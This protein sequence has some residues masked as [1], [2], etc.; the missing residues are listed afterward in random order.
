M[1]VVIAVVGGQ[2]EGPAAT[3]GVAVD[4]RIVAVGLRTC[5]A[6]R[7]AAVLHI[8]KSVAPAGLHGLAGGGEVET[9]IVADARHRVAQ[10]RKQHVVGHSRRQGVESIGKGIGIHRVARAGALHK[11][12]RTPLHLGAR[13]VGT[14]TVPTHRSTMRS[15]AVD[16]AVL[17][18]SIRHHQVVNPSRIG[19]V[20]AATV[21]V[22]DGDVLAGAV[23]AA[24]RNDLLLPAVVGIGRRSDGHKGALVARVAHHAHLHIGGAVV[25]CISEEADRQPLHAVH[26]EH[27]QHHSGVVVAQIAL[28]VHPHGAAAAMLDATVHL[29]I[30]AHHR[31]TRPARRELAVV[32]SLE[33]LAQRQRRVGLEGSGTDTRQVAHLRHRRTS[34]VNHKVVGRIGIEAREFQPLLVAVEG[35]V[36]AVHRD[37][38]RSA[39]TQ[40]ETR[41][42]ILDGHTVASPALTDGIPKHV[43]TVRGDVG[44]GLARH[45][46]RSHLEVVKID[47]VVVAVL[48]VGPQG[49]VAPRIGVR[50][51]AHRAA[52]PA[53]GAV[54]RIDGYK[55]RLILR[56]LHHAHHNAARGIVVA[57]RPEA[58]RQPADGHRVYLRQ[59]RQRTVAASDTEVEAACAAVLGAG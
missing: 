21:I 51:Q 35:C 14:H 40:R 15:D 4:T 24:Q 8:L 5:P 13:K 43:D 18:S 31:R 20:V 45:Q 27:G 6:S 7:I 53:Q 19:A 34:A 46:A 54:H 36:G 30:A 41:R 23:V 26:I 16:R 11:A 33:T 50:G 47:V 3:M 39:Q 28:G 49:N 37:G 1:V 38:H 32:V 48:V 59:H 12:R 42:T 2:I 17:S 29:G 55:T 57:A 56:I 10:R 22:A 44:H 25:L 9:C 58:D 52:H